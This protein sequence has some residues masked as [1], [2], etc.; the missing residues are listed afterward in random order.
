MS[1]APTGQKIQ[2]IVTALVIALGGPLLFQNC[3]NGLYTNAEF[4]KYSSSGAG[5]NG[6]GSG[7]GTGAGGGSGG[8]G[9]NG[10]FNEIDPG[11]GFWAPQTLDHVYVVDSGQIPSFFE[12]PGGLM[13]RE[14][15]GPSSTYYCVDY[16]Q[17]PGVPVVLSHRVGLTISVRIQTPLY[18]T[19]TIRFASCIG[20]G[21][22][23][24]I[25]VSLSEI[26]GDFS[27]PS[28]THRIDS[29]PPLILSSTGED[30][31]CQAPGNHRLYFNFRAI[32]NAF[33][34][35]Q[36]DPNNPNVFTHTPISDGDCT[37]SDIQCPSM[38]IQFTWL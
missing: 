31:H 23:Y 9:N 8:S 16:Y 37:R 13:G 19:A 10:S 4:Q 6:S 15:T 18:A 27:D 20:S 32:K 1:R 24:P 14:G 17:Q 29:A 28:C 25:E 36:R 38:K 22:N 35:V 12:T 11:S 5:G 2:W 33:E 26:P 30:G 3:S 34:L 7:G 21:A